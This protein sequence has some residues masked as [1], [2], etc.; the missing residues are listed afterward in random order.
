VP[1]PTPGPDPSS[2]LIPGPWRHRDISANGT[3]FHVA[4]AGDSE[5]PLVLL[6]HGF[7]EFWWSWRH[8]LVA[9]ADAGYRAVATDLRGYGASDKPPRGY[10]AFTLSADVAGLIRALGAQDAALVGHDW[11]G[12]LSWT[13]AAV[14]PGAVRQLVVV[15]CPHPLRQR[16]A[17]LTQPRGQL[18]ASRYMMSFQLPWRPERRLVADDAALTGQLLHEWG[19][20]AFPDQETE[21][22][23]RD[24]IRIPGVAH[25]ALEYY[26]W[27][28]RS[29]VRSD[30][31]RMV[32]ALERPI[33]PP[34]L[35]LHGS[36]DPAT[37]PATAMG[38]G[39]YVRGKYEWRLFEGLGHFPHEEDPDAVTAEILRW[40]AEGS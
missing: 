20:P 32:R 23:L 8:Q 1:A 3:R 24:A 27:T 17:M 15:S 22:R 29:V 13:S 12:F 31:R 21:R 16:H 38:S 14:H 6:L 26:R 4:E 33:K 36:L 19:G 11:G 2:V 40:L 35:Q 5:A 7:P 10:D 28:I 39:R 18:S 34:T 25:C 37:L 30:G 9:L